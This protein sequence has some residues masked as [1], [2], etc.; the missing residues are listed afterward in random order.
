M[1]HLRILF[2]RK[3]PD[4]PYPHISHVGGLNARGEPWVLAVEDVIQV[5]A[6]T[7]SF[8]VG[9]NGHRSSVFI[10]QGNGSRHI[11]CAADLVE[12][13]NTFLTLPDC[14]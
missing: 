10:A 13:G 11:Q 1:Q 14:P 9:S 6:N 8:S 7:Y 5:S 4:R 12:G 3:A 2:A